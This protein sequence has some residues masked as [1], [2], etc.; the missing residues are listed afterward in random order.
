MIKIIITE[1]NDIIREGL[2]ILINATAGLEC[3]AV[4][5]NCE[6]ML[7]DYKNH[8][9][10]IFLQDIGLPGMSGIEGVKILRNENPEAVILMLTVYEDEENVFEA[11]KAGAS[12]YLLKRTPPNQLIDAIKDAYQGGSP[13]SSNIARKVVRFFSG[14]SKNK[15]SY[16]LSE[17]EKEI[18]SGLAD[19]NSYQVLADELFIS[20]HTVRSHIR[21]IYKKL[22]VHNQSEA[23]A[24]AYK[25][26]II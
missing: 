12:G 20:I 13:M 4:Y 23:V 19:G 16:Q 5:T 2:A 11:L 1:D 7:A 18:I 9:P 8:T 10:D 6:D 17:R 3:S 14:S 26:G 22:H 15:N 21:K 25:E 24:I